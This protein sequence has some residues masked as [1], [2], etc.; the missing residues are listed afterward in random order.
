MFPSPAEHSPSF[1]FQ[2]FLIFILI[3]ILTLF[4][5]VSTCKYQN[6]PHSPSPWQPMIAHIKQAHNKFTLNKVNLMAQGGSVKI[7]EH[8]FILY[9]SYITN[10]NFTPI[11]QIEYEGNNFQRRETLST[12]LKNSIYIIIQKFPSSCFSSGPC[13]INGLKIYLVLQYFY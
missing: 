4:P 9:I 13:T 1:L 7:F 8:L 3:F 12:N 11:K 6:P 10:T 5:I 2:A